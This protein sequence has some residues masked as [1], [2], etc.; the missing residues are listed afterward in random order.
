MK[1]FTLFI[2]SLFL[3]SC[4]THNNFK[5]LPDEG[6][7]SLSKDELTNKYSDIEVYEKEWRGF[8]PNMPFE[9]DLIEK[10]GLPS[11][12]ERSWGPHAL[13]LGLSALIFTDPF[14]AMLIALRPTPMKEYI[15]KKGK[16]CIK[17][18][19]SYDVFVGY[20][21]YVVNW[22]WMEGNAECA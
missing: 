15:F 8:S 10:L 3:A 19:I 2:C 4:I 13:T 1:I 12:I 11:K 21:D 22:K 17:A 20:E 9:K 7:Y 18:I 5:K 6:E 16:Y 14:L